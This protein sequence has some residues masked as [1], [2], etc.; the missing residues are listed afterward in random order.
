M[1]KV[2][3]TLLYYYKVIVYFS[4][5]FIPRRFSMTASNAETSDSFA[6]VNAACALFKLL[7]SSGE[8]EVAVDVD[9]ERATTYI[10]G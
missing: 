9:M 1:N 3:N 4:L 5:V 7:T 2:S 8:Q 10:S 6:E